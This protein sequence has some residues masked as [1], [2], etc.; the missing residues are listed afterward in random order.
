MRIERAK[1]QLGLNER[2]TEITDKKLR[3][4][5]QLRHTVEF[6]FLSGDIMA[7]TFI[8]TNRCFKTK[9]GGIFYRLEWR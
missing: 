3:Q 2:I 8:Y 4:I 7:P 6:Q 9:F 5:Q 1:V